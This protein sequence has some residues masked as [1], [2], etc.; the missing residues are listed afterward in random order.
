MIVDDDTGKKQQ[1][2]KNNSTASAVIRTNPSRQMRSTPKEGDK[3]SNECNVITNN[4]KEKKTDDQR[5]IR[6][7]LN[8]SMKLM[9]EDHI[10]NDDLRHSSE[11]Q[12][13]EDNVKSQKIQ[14]NTYKSFSDT[15]VYYNSQR[16]KYIYPHCGQ[17]VPSTRTSKHH[18]SKSIHNPRLIGQYKA[19]SIL[20]YPSFTVTPQEC[21]PKKENIAHHGNNQ[22][23]NIA[24]YYKN[25]NSMIELVKSWIHTQCDIDSHSDFN[26][27]LE[28]ALPSK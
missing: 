11:Q 17:S 19:K 27:N 6:K 8:K 22:C 18:I 9:N 7:F 20:L 21:L 12:T 3:T 26:G 24:T 2:K 4:N 5:I 10:N 15:N 28:Y 1:L 16:E 14:Q 13:K 25:D 23:L